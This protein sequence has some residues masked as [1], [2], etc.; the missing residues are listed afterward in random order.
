MLLTTNRVTCAE[1]SPADGVSPP[2]IPFPYPTNSLKAPTYCCYFFSGAGRDKNDAGTNDQDRDGG[3]IDDHLEQANASE[4]KTES[5][6]SCSEE[7]GGRTKSSSNQPETLTSG[8]IERNLPGQTNVASLG[9]SKNDPKQK[10]LLAQGHIRVLVFVN[11]I[12]AV[13]L[14]SPV[15]VHTTTGLWLVCALGVEAMHRKT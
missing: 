8:D 5:G 6:G 7:D 10:S 11:G 3:K 2:I 9:Q 15:H 14:L 12:F 13:R 4:E 1:T